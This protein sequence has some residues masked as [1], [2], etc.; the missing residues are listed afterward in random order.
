M[1]D[2]LFLFRYAAVGRFT[3]VTTACLEEITLKNVYL[4][5]EKG[6]TLKRK[7]FA[8]IRDNCQKYFA[9][10]LKR[11]LHEKEWICSQPFW[12]GSTLKGRKFILFEVDPFSEGT[13]CI[14]K[15][16]G[17]HKN[18]LPCTA[19]QVYPVPLNLSALGWYS[20]YQFLIR[21]SRRCLY[22]SI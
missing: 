9:S 19:Y 12:K 13:W 21:I 20:V 7:E 17:S 15:Q 4:P 3:K 5:S 22:K 11:G 6:S 2:V 18:C 16:T 1:V 14:G 10:L 8:L